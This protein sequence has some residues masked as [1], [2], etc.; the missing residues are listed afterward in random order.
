M[1]GTTSTRPP[2]GPPQPALRLLRRVPAGIAMTAWRRRAMPLPMVPLEPHPPSYLHQTRRR[3]RP[4]DRRV[5]TPRT[6]LGRHIRRRL[7]HRRGHRRRVIVTMTAR[8]T[9]PAELRSRI[10][11]GGT[12]CPT[13]ALGTGPTAASSA[14]RNC[15]PTRRFPRARLV[16][17]P[18]SR[19]HRLRQAIRDE[20]PDTR[21]PNAH[22]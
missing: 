10:H 1:T 8:T 6:R 15:R 22:E 14:A 21:G 7:A 19:R 2:D 20:L 5:T 12:I 18:R 4:T 3:S 17:R 9:A 11:D 16:Y 13:C